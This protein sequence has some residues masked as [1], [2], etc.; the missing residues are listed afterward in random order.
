MAAIRPIRV[1]QSIIDS[2]EAEPR[3]AQTVDRRHGRR[4]FPLRSNGEPYSGINVP[5]R[6]AAHEGYTAAHWFT[7]NRRKTRW[8]GPKRREIIHRGQVRD[9]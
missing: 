1:T 4:C 9:I 7:Y 2:M 3:M 5:A 8:T 6:L